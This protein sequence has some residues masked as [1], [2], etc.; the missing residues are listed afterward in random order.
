M[1]RYNT[2]KALKGEVA[3]GHLVSLVLGLAHMSA[4]HQKVISLLDILQCFLFCIYS[5]SPSSQGGL[6]RGC[7][8]CRPLTL[9]HSW[10]VPGVYREIWGSMPGMHLSWQGTAST[11]HTL[12]TS[13]GSTNWSPQI[14]EGRQAVDLLAM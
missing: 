4:Y 2:H 13:G 11:P 12:G 14:S 5:W 3:I 1:D 9:K 8:W 10:A 7:V 6:W